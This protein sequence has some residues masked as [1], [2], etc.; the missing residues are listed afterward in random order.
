MKLKVDEVDMIS[1]FQVR[2]HILSREVGYLFRVWMNWVKKLSVNLF[3]RKI[4]ENLDLYIW[5]FENFYCYFIDDLF[6]LWNGSKKKLLDF[7]AKLNTCHASTKFDYKHFQISTDLP[8]TT[9]QKD[10]GQNKL[11]ITAYCKPTDHKQILHHKSVH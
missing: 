10:K 7:I 4:W 8:D 2:I 1:S 5:S 9:V 11:L 6:L 3:I